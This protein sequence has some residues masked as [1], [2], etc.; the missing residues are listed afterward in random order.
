[1]H[2]TANDCEQ[3]T[4]MAAGYVNIYIVVIATCDKY[5]EKKYSILIASYFFRTSFF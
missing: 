5:K 1:M 2:T 3:A 4:A